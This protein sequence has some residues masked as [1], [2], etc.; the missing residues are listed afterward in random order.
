[1]LRRGALAAALLA[2]AAVGPAAAPLPAQQDAYQPVPEAPQLVADRPDITESTSILPPGW[3]QV[4]TGASLERDDGTETLAGPGTLLRLGVVPRVEARLSWDGLVR[5]EEDRGGCGC[6]ISGAGDGEASVK[7]LLVER[8]GARPDVALLPA[9]TLP[10][11]DD[12]LGSGR[13]DPGVKAL[14][15]NDLSERVGWA[16]NVG[17]SWPTE[18]SNGDRS[19]VRTAGWSLSFGIG[20]A[21]RLGAFVEYFGEDPDASPAAHALDTGLTYLISPHAQVD[22]TGGVGLGDAAPDWFAGTGL[23][24]RVP[25]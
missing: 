14:L 21:E 2:L 20:L 5:R 24:L 18:E 8:G 7:V 19:R 6:E 4:E 25:R 13:A 11:G 22:A 17:L 3:L 10:W 1:M 16:A 23:V 15:G 12:E 9:L